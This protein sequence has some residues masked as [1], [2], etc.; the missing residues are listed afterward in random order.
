MNRI[1]KKTKRVLAVALALVLML[2]FLTIGAG[3]SNGV[4]KLEGYVIDTGMQLVYVDYDELSAQLVRYH[5]DMPG[6]TQ[7][8]E[9]YNS[10]M[11]T[12]TM[13]AY[14]FLGDDG[15]LEWVSYE[16]LSAAMVAMYMSL[17]AD[18]PL[19]AEK[20][21]DAAYAV[22]V[23]AFTEDEEDNVI[24]SISFVN[25][26]VVLTEAWVIGPDGVPVPYEGEDI[27]DPD[28]PL[29]PGHPGLL[30]LITVTSGDWVS[31]SRRTETD[32]LRVY[33][34]WYNEGTGV[35]YY[36]MPGEPLG[37]DGERSYAVRN[38]P[39]RADYDELDAFLTSFEAGS[40]F[41][42]DEYGRVWKIDRKGS[43]LGN[44]STTA[45]STVDPVR[46]DLILH[47]DIVARN[48]ELDIVDN[49]TVTGEAYNLI[50]TRTRVLNNRISTAPSDQRTLTI[51]AVLDNL[52]VAATVY[53]GS[54]P[55]VGCSEIQLNTNIRG[56]VVLEAGLL[57]PVMVPPVAERFIGG[58]LTVV[59][60]I[61]EPATGVNMPTNNDVIPS[62]IF[63][64]RGDATFNTLNSD[65]AGGAAKNSI[66]GNVGGDLVVDA[67]RNNNGLIAGTVT[68][69]ATINFAGV[70]FGDIVA[71]L[72]GGQ[73]AAFRRG[74][75]VDIRNVGKNV[76][77]NYEGYTIGNFTAPLADASYNVVPT[78]F[79][80]VNIGTLAGNPPGTPGTT[81]EPSGSVGGNLNV[82]YGDVTIE[83]VGTTVLTRDL[84]VTFGSVTVGKNVAVNDQRRGEVG[85]DVN[86][87]VGNLSIGDV[88]SLGSNGS[89]T[90]RYG[91]V[92]IGN[93]VVRQDGRVGG[94]LNYTIGNTTTG[95][96]TPGANRIFI[97]F[98]DIWVAGPGPS[99][100][101]YRVV[102]DVTVNF[103]LLNGGFMPWARVHT[104]GYVHVD[105]TGG[106]VD[107]NARSYGVD[108][109]HN[110]VES[111]VTVRGL[112]RKTI[113]DNQNA[114]AA[115]G[116]ITGNT[117]IESDRVLGTVNAGINAATAGRLSGDLWISGIARGAVVNV[118]T[119]FKDDANVNVGGLA[120]SQI[121][122]EWIRG[123]NSK[124]E[125]T[126]GTVVIKEIQRLDVPFTL[127][128]PVP[129]I[130]GGNV[131]L[132][133][134][135]LRFDVP[136]G[137][138]NYIIGGNEAGNNATRA[139]GMTINSGIPGA[140]S[141]AQ[142][143]T[144][145]AVYSTLGEVDF[146]GLTDGIATSA[147]NGTVSWTIQSERNVT[148]PPVARALA[149]ITLN[150]DGAG[151][152]TGVR[153]VYTGAGSV[154]DVEDPKFELVPDG[155]YTYDDGDVDQVPDDGT[156]RVGKSGENLGV[157]FFGTGDRT[158]GRVVH[159]EPDPGAESLFFQSLGVDGT[160]VYIRN[161]L[162]YEFEIGMTG[163]STTLWLPEGIFEDPL[164]VNGPG[165][166]AANEDRVLE[167]NGI[168]MPDLDLVGTGIIKVNGKV[169]TLTV[170]DSGSPLTVDLTNATVSLIR[171]YNDVKGTGPRTVILGAGAK[172]VIVVDRIDQHT[173]IVVGNID[174]ALIDIGSFNHGTNLRID[175]S[176]MQ[177]TSSSLTITLGSA[178]STSLL[179]G[180][181][182]ATETSLATISSL[183]TASYT[184]LGADHEIAIAT[185]GMSAKLNPVDVPPGSLLSGQPGQVIIRKKR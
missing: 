18:D 141:A 151:N 52:T 170:K 53:N 159:I 148:T 169:E 3:A 40:R 80:D 79:G 22:T 30:G 21:R 120:G 93:N 42:L 129:V 180:A 137:L 147:R 97:E 28:E 75:S 183:A 112:G 164:T 176:G 70:Q 103:G 150:V 119:V 77:V 78:T 6:D 107:I 105:L 182:V 106:N 87:E 4:R 17:P 134:N 23:S 81:P 45:A 14:V 184:S 140:G 35:L 166:N 63:N 49:I 113:G 57:R 55:A 66:I 13:V 24:F 101:N 88:V 82:T 2:S 175:Y 69:N 158:S 110:T 167:L 74:G 15:S 108:F 39:G 54:P 5:L 111:N 132:P 38:A 19:R 37:I 142:A 41:T 20:A 32:P 143:G 133:P 154:Q 85:G 118:G 163:D 29:G 27:D 179:L 16:A 31:R 84:V 72:S 146:R 56:N 62:G 177:A 67:I 65:L 155:T 91:N 109:E 94:D 131:T 64:V 149:V 171:I 124:I 46:Q 165:Q 47:R 59:S 43:I 34:F 104:T 86:V 71:P 7:L 168:N 117:R 25:G 145:T 153:V 36:Q 121:T 58:N 98:P 76:S 156:F 68:G 50:L 162:I 12:G 135:V 26:N 95:T 157:L 139:G 11:A 136:P 73:Q 92:N 44:T 33:E 122:I 144:I 1:L 89:A 160:V 116:G 51:S 174:G 185:V 60:G 152:I 90:V 9:Y 178:T 123:V 61:V 126:G 114:I 100:M 127:I 128:S 172:N 115:F 161:G 96:T 99:P 130:R 10:V 8:Y 173:E 48:L 125:V 102:G 181:G 138:P 83:Q